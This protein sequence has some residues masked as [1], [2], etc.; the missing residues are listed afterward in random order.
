MYLPEKDALIDIITKLRRNHHIT[1]RQIAE[2][3]CIQQSTISNIIGK[4]VK[5]HKEEPTYE[6]AQ[7]IYNAIL[8]IISP[9][10]DEPITKIA[11][12][13]SDVESHGIV[14]ST[15][16]ISEVAKLM[17]DGGYTQLLVKNN[18]GIVEGVIT[19]LTLLVQMI[20]AQNTD[21]D[22]LR[23]LK[24]KPIKNLIER[25]SK[26]PEN[27]TQAEVAQMLTYHYAVAVDEGKQKYGIVTRNDFMKLL[28]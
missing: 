8:Q 13:S 25:A 7:K 23:R 3:S 10:E 26:T 17:K 15:A 24:E 11:T 27:S 14:S 2:I 6:E 18:E 22:W 4:N 16:T 1:E 9:F 12:S 20:E 28:T 19:D 5:R 21:K